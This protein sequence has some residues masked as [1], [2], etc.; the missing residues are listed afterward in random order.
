MKDKDDE[1]WQSGKNKIMTIHRTDYDGNEW[2]EDYVDEYPCKYRPSYG[3]LKKYMDKHK[4]KLDTRSPYEQYLD[5]TMEQM[6]AQ[7]GWHFKH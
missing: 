7:K 5:D 4:R 3:A 1:W 6:A 2:D